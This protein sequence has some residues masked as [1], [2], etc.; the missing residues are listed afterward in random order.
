V[1]LLSQHISDVIKVNLDDAKQFAQLTDASEG[2]TLLIDFFDD[3]SYKA[4]IRNV[5]VDYDKV[6]G[7]TAQIVDYE[8][9]YCFISVSDAGISLRT[10]IYHADKQFQTSQINGQLIHTQFKL[11]ENRNQ[12]LEN[13][14]I[15][16]NLLDYAT[17]TDIH[18]LQSPA[19]DDLEEHVTV[20]VMVVY[21]T[22]ARQWADRNATSID[23]AISMAFQYANQVLV[24]SQINMTLSLV[25]KYESDYPE[26]D[27]A[28]MDLLSL[29]DSIDGKLDEV[30]SLRRQYAADIVV[31]LPMTGAFS[32]MPNYDLNKPDPTLGFS[33]CNI[34]G[35]TYN[36][37]FIHELGH[38][39]G[40]HHHWQQLRS[41]SP[42]PGIF[43][44][45]SAW[46]GMGEDSVWYHT[47]MSYSGINF[48]DKIPSVLIP[49]FSN[50]EVIVHGVSIGSVKKENNSLTINQTKHTIARYSELIGA[51][52]SPVL[53]DKID[54][55][56]LYAY[57][58]DGILHIC[59]MK[60]GQKFYVFTII[61][62]PIYNGISKSDN[63][64]I[65]LPNRG[66][67]ILISD[68]KTIK[69]YSK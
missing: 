25:Y 21:S 65:S 10:D 6:I 11:S 36:S 63:E 52:T 66:F 62:Q 42:G 14:L 56:D 43:S 28:N 29:R 37:T 4:I 27:D 53:I 20:D 35:A 7:I 5:T 64:H 33:V 19:D 23:N 34:S 15:I 8:V 50:P 61:G 3:N 48:A 55:Q 40:A 9:A 1:N 30:Y 67:Y 46:R 38:I 58:T 41:K 59:N 45:S 44:Y 49:Y 12:N 31:L 26:S 57:A 60:S 39:F 32:Y 51:K 68:E 18:A 17:N 2:D 54:I 47:V 24:N 16:S 69:F 13:D 22:K